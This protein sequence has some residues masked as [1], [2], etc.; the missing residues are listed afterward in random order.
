METALA[1][2]DRWGVIEG[3]LQPLKV[4]VI[5]ELPEHLKDSAGLAEKLKRD[6]SKLLTMLQY[7]KHQGD[8]KQYI[9]DY[10]GIN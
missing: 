8:R 9:H 6:Q 7:V 5:S 1:M 3:T 10:F 4:K 2:M